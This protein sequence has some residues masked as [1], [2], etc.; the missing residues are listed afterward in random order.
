[1]RVL[2]NDFVLNDP[3]NR[4]YLNDQIEGLDYPDI[5]T[6]KGML[7]G[8]NGG[9]IGAQFLEPR[10]ISIIGT[11][12]SSDVTEAKQ[13]RRNIQAALPLHPEVIEVV[14]E[15][16]DG[17]TY[18]VYA[19][20]ISFKMPIERNPIKSRFKIELEAPDPIIYDNASGS[21]LTVTLQRVVQGGF[22]WPITWPLVWASASGAV[23]VNNNGTTFVQPTITLTDT[24]TNPVL[25]NETTGQVFEFDD[26]T[27]TAGDV[28]LID[29][30]ARTVTL[31]GGSIL[32]KV[33]PSSTWWGLEVGSNDIKLET[34]SGSDDVTGELSWRN[35]LLGI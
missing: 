11:I 6:S 20:L 33:V 14:I 13:K 8:Q 15:D 9:F 17:A 16:D 10:A 12:F 32:Q 27:T 29:M 34:S 24:M 22:T 1:M 26:L 21:E 18:L 19:N 5:R 3:D 23:T 28:V 25:T 7:S 31:N 2:L 30:R 35:G 4:V